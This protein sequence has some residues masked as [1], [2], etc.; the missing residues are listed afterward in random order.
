MSEHI[1]DLDYKLLEDWERHCEG[2]TKMDSFHFS[3]ILMELFALK[4]TR[5]VEDYI[6]RFSRYFTPRIFKS[7]QR[8]CNDRNATTETL[9][10]IN[11]DLDEKQKIAEEVVP[12]STLVDKL[13]VRNIVIESNPKK[14]Y[15]LCAPNDEHCLLYDI[16]CDYFGEHS[17][18]DDRKYALHEAL[19]NI[20]T[21]NFLAY[22]IMSDMITTEV[23][24]SNYLE[25][26]LCGGAY[27]LME[28]YI[29]VLN[30]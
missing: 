21:D 19:Y 7:L 20:A 1:A 4:Y 18:S 29:Y 28:N 6:Y 22:S 2:N 17:I 26:Y 5:E 24:Y 14:Y 25:V 11:R 13:R 30:Q 16:Q 3:T 15:K 12:N 10:W 27:M 9:Y 23:D 8:I